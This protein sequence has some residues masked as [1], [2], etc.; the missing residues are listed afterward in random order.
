[1]PDTCS[2]PTLPG[3]PPLIRRDTP[4]GPQFLLDGSPLQARDVVEVWHTGRCWHRGFI[5]V[6]DVDAV[7][8]WNDAYGCRLSSDADFRRYVPEPVVHVPPMVYRDVKDW[9]RRGG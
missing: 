2:E 3:M 4:A 9:E 6:V 1:M 7:F 8:V 5:A